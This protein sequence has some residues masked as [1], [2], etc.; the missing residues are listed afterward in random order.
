M[1][2]SRKIHLF[3]DVV[4]ISPVTQ[5]A[6][7]AFAVALVYRVIVPLCRV[8]VSTLGARNEAVKEREKKIHGDKTNNAIRK[9]MENGGADGKGRQSG[10]GISLKK[11]QKKVDAASKG[12]GGGGHAHQRR[13]ESDLFVATVGVHPDAVGG[14][15]FSPTG[16]YLATVC[17]REV[18]VYS[19]PGDEKTRE[20]SRKKTVKDGSVTASFSPSCD[21]VVGCPRTLVDVAWGGSES[22]VVVLTYGGS[23]DAELQVVEVGG[24]RSGG[25][26]GRRK[27]A[28]NNNTNNTIN[29][30]NIYSSSG[31]GGYPLFGQ[32]GRKRQEEPLCL[33]GSSGSPV[34]V[35][36][37][38]SE[39]SKGSV[40]SC[41]ASSG[42]PVLRHVKDVDFAGIKNYDAAISQDGRFLAAATFTADVKVYRVADLMGEHGGSVV[43]AMDLGGHKK[44]ITSIAF[45]PDGKKAVTA[46]EDGTLRIWN[47]DVRYSLQ[48]GAKL[49]VVAGLPSPD[50]TISHLSWSRGGEGIIAAACGSDLYMIDPGSGQAVATVMGAHAAP[51]TDM[52]WSP[53]IY[54]DSRDA[55]GV[56]MH[57]DD[58]EASP[59]FVLL[60]TASSD[61]LVRLWRPRPC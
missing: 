54:H 18:R 26:T 60:A 47:I 10:G 41:G 52:T 9:K 7:L 29:I 15:A 38:V 6:I 35:M 13:H 20:G 55:R 37:A 27:N 51:I 58:D 8:L 57:T 1:L 33:K 31:G 2:S 32:S 36:L 59:S 61:G 5:V 39:D 14:L 11:L 45:S 25:S 44:K 23:G 19:L 22:N 40:Y 42:T 56:Q 12:G 30:A 34:V 4:E 24:D 3:D 21:L 53:G 28:A 50:K 17:D 49:L 43:K 46:S 48:E 16:R